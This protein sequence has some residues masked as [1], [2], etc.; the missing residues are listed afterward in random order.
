MLFFIA[1]NIYFVLVHHIEAD[2]LSSLCKQQIQILCEPS[3]W[4]HTFN[5]L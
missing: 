4:K 1:K 3:N 5:D 2:E